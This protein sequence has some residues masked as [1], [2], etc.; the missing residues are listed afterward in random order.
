MPRS[1]A[2]RRACCCCCC[3][4]EPTDGPE[5]GRE[6]LGGNSNPTTERVYLRLVVQ[7]GRQR[8]DRDGASGAGKRR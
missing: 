4:L 5:A 6:V 1:P 2:R 3:C 7:A 8:A